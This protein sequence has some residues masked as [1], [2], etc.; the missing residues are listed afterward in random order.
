MIN[1]G[2]EQ[3]RERERE[4]IMRGGGGPAK[5]D[6]HAFRSVGG[7]VVFVQLLELLH[8]CS[9]QESDKVPYAAEAKSHQFTRRKSGLVEKADELA[10][11]YF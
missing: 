6:D 1:L 7:K 11:L 8:L 10:R 2:R 9:R 3:E 4:P 5:Q